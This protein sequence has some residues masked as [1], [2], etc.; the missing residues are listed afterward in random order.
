M[1]YDLK[2]VICSK[3]VPEDRAKRGAITCDNEHSK[4]LKNRRR[5]E[6]SGTSC[7]L[8]G[9]RIRKPRTETVLTEQGAIE[10]RVCADGAQVGS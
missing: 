7:R 2:C 5:T 1:S 6:K 10:I 4:L 8:C 9:R 3:E